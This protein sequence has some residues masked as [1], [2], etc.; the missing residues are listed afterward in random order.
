M[1]KGINNMACLKE[2]GSVSVRR[3]LPARGESYPV[4]P[5]CSQ[6]LENCATEAVCALLILVSHLWGRFCKTQHVLF[7]REILS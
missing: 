3:N 6:L 5:V 1:P 2:N 4:G 7:E